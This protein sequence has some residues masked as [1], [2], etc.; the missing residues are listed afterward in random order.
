MNRINQVHLLERE[1]ADEMVSD[2]QWQAVAKL[3]ALSRRE[4]EV[5]QKLFLGKTRQQVADDLGIKNRTARQYVE[6]L[7]QKLRVTNRTGLVLRI[8]QLRDGMDKNQY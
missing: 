7:H 3:V 1:P 8:V 5:C 6:Q 2:F 4:L